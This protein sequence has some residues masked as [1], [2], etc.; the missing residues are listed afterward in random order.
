MNQ[1]C[2][3]QAKDTNKRQTI[4]L[5]TTHNTYNAILFTKVNE[6]LVIKKNYKYQNNIS[7]TIPN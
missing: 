3:L 7:L 2:V 4:K 6:G 1:T 5:Y